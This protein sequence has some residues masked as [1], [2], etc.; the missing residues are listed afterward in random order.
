VHRRLLCLGALLGTASALLLAGGSAGAPGRTVAPLH[1]LSNYEY[2]HGGIH[3]QLVTTHTGRGIY[4]L[5]ISTR[6][7]LSDGNPW[8]VQ[9]EQVGGEVAP[10]N[11]YTGH[12]SIQAV[13]PQ[14]G[15]REEIEGL[16][17]GK[18]LDRDTIA[19]SF[20]VRRLDVH[21]KVARYPHGASRGHYGIKLHYT[22]HFQ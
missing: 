5:Q 12:F 3:V 6:C 17:D 7:N 2:R 21:C 14:D 13:F 19:F 16:V 10:I 9:T 8:V 11:H 1:D 15:S 4:T 20:S 18:E 22:G